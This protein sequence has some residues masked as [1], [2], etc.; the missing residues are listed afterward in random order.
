M[1]ATGTLRLNCWV[2]GDDV[3]QVFPVKITN[4]ESVGTLKKAIR[5][6]KLALQHVDADSLTLEGLR[7]REP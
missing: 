6:E 3:S 4:T 2:F 1:S 5:D 7:S